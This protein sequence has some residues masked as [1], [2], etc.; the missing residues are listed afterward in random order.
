M[1]PMSGDIR[2][3]LRRK[4]N[5]NTIQD[6]KGTIKTDPH[7][8]GGV[9][10]PDISKPIPC[11]LKGQKGTKSPK[12]NSRSNNNDHFDHIKTFSPAVPYHPPYRDG[13]IGRLSKPNRARTKQKSR[14]PDRHRLDGLVHLARIQVDPQNIHSRQRLKNNSFI[15]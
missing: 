5:K 13:T 12:D 15:K 2:Q 1:P 6:K 10:V 9:L 8:R 4:F 7:H 14:P 11:P 3:P